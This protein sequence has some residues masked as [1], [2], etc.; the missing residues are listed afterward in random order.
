M[1]PRRS[2]ARGSGEEVALLTDGRF[3]GA[4]RGLMAGHV[5]PEAVRGGPIA[6]IRDG[7][8]ITLRRRGPPAR[9]RPAGRRDRRAGRRLPSRPSRPYDQRRDGQ[10]RAQRL[11]GLAGRGHQLAQSARKVSS[12]RLKRIGRSSCGRWP[13]SSKITSA[14]CAG[15]GRSRARP[16]AAPRGRFGPRR[17]ASAPRPRPAGRGCRSR[18]APGRRAG[19]PACRRRFRTAPEHLAAQ[20]LGVLEQPLEGRPANAGPAHAALLEPSRSGAA[21]VA[22]RATVSAG[23]RRSRAWEIPG[24][25]HQHELLEP[26]GLGGRGLGRDEAAHRV[27]DHGAVAYLQRLAEAV[28]QAPVALDRDLPVGHRRVAEPGRSSAS[29]RCSRA[30]WGMFSSQFCHE[31]ERPWTKTTGIRAPEPSST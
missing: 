14:S 10:V 4:T 1:S 9:R 17:S 5:A 21:A 22:I 7:D 29:T 15:A 2:S 24:G 3:S 18:P 11:V 19:S 6:A 28:Q 26:A 12:R 27:S 16:A 20:R 8:E 23:W 25:G 31:P 30:K 13:V